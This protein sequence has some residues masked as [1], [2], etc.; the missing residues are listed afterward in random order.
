MAAGTAAAAGAV[1][2]GI[3]SISDV[4]G[5]ALGLGTC[6][7]MKPR[8]LEPSL[9]F[10]PVGGA[11]STGVSSVVAAASGAD[12]SAATGSA[13]SRSDLTTSGSLARTAI[14]GVISAAGCS[15][16][17]VSTAG[18]SVAEGSTGLV[19]SVPTTGCSSAADMRKEFYFNE[20]LPCDKDRRSREVDLQEDRV[21][22][23]RCLERKGE[24]RRNV[25]AE[26]YST[27]C[28]TKDKS[29]IGREKKTGQREVCV[30]AVD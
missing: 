16:G 10:S 27:E 1:A 11:G 2:A 13:F 23:S 22:M 28:V 4:A 29:R 3:G 19:S 25:E 21:K 15:A 20:Y 30:R 8:R 17:V 9:C 24:D 7:L 14:S 26:S 18:V 12:G 5:F 6:F